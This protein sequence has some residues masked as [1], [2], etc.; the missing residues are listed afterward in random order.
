MAVAAAVVA[1]NHP[2]PLAASPPGSV[3][4]VGAPHRHHAPKWIGSECPLGVAA[5]GVAA[6]GVATMGV[7]ANPPWGAMTVVGEVGAPHLGPSSPPLVV[8]A[9][10]A[11]GKDR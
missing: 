10:V 9:A 2:W 5:V 1:A 11:G 7:V 6:V 3:V 4:V 8:G